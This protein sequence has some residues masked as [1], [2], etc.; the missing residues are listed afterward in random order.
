VTDTWEAKAELLSPRTGFSA[1]VL[2]G[3]IFVIGGSERPGM[4]G[5]GSVER[6]DPANDE[7][8]AES[9]LGTARV[10]LTSCAFGGKI[11]TIGGAA[12]PWPFE[13]LSTVEVLTYE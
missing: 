8:T 1:A 4:E 3:S 13:P 6:Y 10:A 7:W 5:L 12:G 2:N 9:D 11:Y